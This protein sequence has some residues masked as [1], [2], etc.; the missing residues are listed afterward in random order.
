MKGCAETDS[1]HL[2]ETL[3]KTVSKSRALKSTSHRTPKLRRH[4]RGSF[5]VRLVDGSTRW[6]GSDPERAE[7]QYRRLVDCSYLATERSAPSA[8]KV[9]GEHRVSVML[10]PSGPATVQETAQR[11]FRLVD[12]ESGPHGKKKVRRSLKRFLA[13]VGSR[14][15]DGLTADDLIDYKGKMVAELAPNTINDYLTYT[16]RLLV[17]ASETGA[18]ARPFQLGILKNV[19]RR[20]LWSK[21]IKSD[22]I[23]VLLTE[24]YKVNPSAARLMLLQF[25]CVM[26]PS[27][28]PKLLHRLGEERADG[29]FAIEGK[30]TRKSGELRPVLLT[31]DSRRLLESIPTTFQKGDQLKPRL[32]T[33]GA[34]GHRVWTVGRKLRKLHGDAW[35]KSIIGK[36]DLSP[37]FLRHSANQALIDAKVPEEYRR[38]AMG[39]LKPRVDR[40]YGTENY[41]AAT[42]AIAILSTLVPLETVGM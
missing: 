13:A 42:Q 17:F 5:F 41:E 23:R 36:R 6:L 34:Y 32:M 2:S 28:A 18:V 20:P 27:E 4:C 21:G 14:P 11:L 15:I 31:P 33:S 16:R 7:A 12:S 35:L 30:T 37:H 29:T 10:V 38:A 39:R 3:A 19:N 24:A 22:A 25:L 9:D 1:P 8:L 26:R 40:T